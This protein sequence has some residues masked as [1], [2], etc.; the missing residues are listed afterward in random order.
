MEISM[1]MLKS[2]S[3]LI[4]IC[5]KIWN[6]LLNV[7]FVLKP[8]EIL[9]WYKKNHSLDLNVI[10]IDLSCISLKNMCLEQSRCFK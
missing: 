9:F 8:W 2:I 3:I 4:L 6:L 1:E 10:V 7:K 5:K